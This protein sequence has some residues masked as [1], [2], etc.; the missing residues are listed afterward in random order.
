MGLRGKGRAFQ[1]VFHFVDANLC[2][3]AEEEQLIAQPD[4]P[5]KGHGQSYEASLASWGGNAMECRWFSGFTWPLRL[6]DLD[7]EYIASSFRLTSGGRYTYRQE[8]SS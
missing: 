1:Q 2:S 6:E 4:A 5:T 8:C 7:L 3:Q